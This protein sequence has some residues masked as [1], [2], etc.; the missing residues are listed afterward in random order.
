MGSIVPEDL[1]LG[2]PCP[3][4]TVKQLLEHIVMVM[5]RVAILGNGGPVALGREFAIADEFLGGALFA[6]KMIPDVDRGTE[7]M[8]F[9]RVVDP[10]P[11]ASLLPQT[12]G[13]M[14]RQVV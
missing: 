1:A 10:G 2:T 6:A 14:G 8:P 3:D 9:S 7:A 4:F 5:R 13:W 11:N 12:A